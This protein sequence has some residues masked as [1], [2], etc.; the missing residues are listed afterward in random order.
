MPDERSKTERDISRIALL[1]L[2]QFHDEV[3]RTGGLVAARHRDRLHCRLGCTDCCLDDLTV[4]TVEAE[5]IRQTF[6]EVLEQDPHP[7]G[8]C[9]FLGTGGACRV[10]T[11]RPY[12]C[13]TQG[14]PLR[15]LEQD[16]EGRIIEYRDICPLNEPDG[17]PLDTLP[18]AH[19][20]TIGPWEDWL[21]SIQ[22]NYAGDQQRVHLRQLFRQ[23]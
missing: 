13:R 22:Q 18:E 12:V 5:R 8:A 20:W 19:C 21:A 10:Y 2:E 23:G 16:D 11:A 9:A 3:D 6:P 1:K 4:F 7:P 14:L 15:Y 17:P